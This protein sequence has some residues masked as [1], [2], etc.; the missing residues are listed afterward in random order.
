MINGVVC[1]QNKTQPSYINNYAD[2]PV[3][4]IPKYRFT[5][6]LPEV[7]LPGTSHAVRC[8]DV[9]GNVPKNTS[10]DNIYVG[11]IFVNYTINET[12]ETKI[13]VGKFTDHFSETL[14]LP[15][16]MECITK[17]LYAATGS[18]DLEINQK[19]GEPI[20]INGVACRKSGY[21]WNVSYGGYSITI[22]NGTSAYIAKAND[23]E[24]PWLEIKCTDENGNPLQNN[25]IGAVY[26]GTLY[27]NYTRIRTGM[28]DIG[29]GEI[30]AVF[31]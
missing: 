6:F 30:L 10:T 27:I 15:S 14:L 28:K 8:T 24:R 2:D 12:G 9:A 4:L 20:Q 25:T 1:T 23:P 7:S 16:G 22:N 19:I 21:A 18:L 11:W 5:S 26:Y 31:E 3:I 13:A 17:K 29:E